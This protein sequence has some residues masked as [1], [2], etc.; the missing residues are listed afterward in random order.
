M[1]WMSFLVGAC[2]IAAGIVV[3]LLGDRTVQSPDRGGATHRVF[4]WPP[5]RAP[6]MKYLFGAAIIGVGIWFFT[7]GAD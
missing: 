7:F 5:R 1:A 4:A 2:L 3:I 6:W